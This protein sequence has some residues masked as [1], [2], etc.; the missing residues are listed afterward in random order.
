MSAEAEGVRY[1]RHA[2]CVQAPV[3]PQRAWPVVFH[4]HL[5]CTNSAALHSEIQRDR[6]AFQRSGQYLSVVLSIG[7]ASTK[8]QH[9]ADQNLPW[10]RRDRGQITLQLAVKQHMKTERKFIWQPFRRGPELRTH[11]HSLIHTRARADLY[12]VFVYRNCT[13]N[14]RQCDLS[15][16]SDVDLLA[17]LPWHWH[18]S[19][20]LSVCLRPSLPWGQPGSFPPMAVSWLQSHQGAKG[21]YQCLSSPRLTR[22]TDGHF[23][24]RALSVMC[25]TDLVILLMGLV[26]N[27][28]AHE[29]WDEQNI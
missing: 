11:T 7:E 23:Q 1:Q 15:D 8:C 14:Q 20:G 16:V 18:G 6:W 13:F 17:L 22:H 27:W 2:Y 26:E 5:R 10:S 21:P 19:H 12:A 24:F 3:L 25:L 4:F 28:M 29:E 9:P